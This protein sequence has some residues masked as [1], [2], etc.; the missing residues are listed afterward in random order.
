MPP[1]SYV[2]S[3]GDV[4]CYLVE[5]RTT[6]SQEWI[7]RWTVILRNLGLFPR[8][9]SSTHYELRG[10]IVLIQLLKERSLTWSVSFLLHSS[11]PYNLTYIYPQHISSSSHRYPWQGFLWLLIKRSRTVVL[12]LFIRSGIHDPPRI[13]NLLRNTLASSFIEFI[14]S[15]LLLRL[16]YGQFKFSDRELVT[17]SHASL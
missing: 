11:S 12:R 5:T 3:F 9:S 6:S 1:Y 4:R 13:D 2:V 8:G 10:R 14:S 15:L 7:A 16:N 17:L